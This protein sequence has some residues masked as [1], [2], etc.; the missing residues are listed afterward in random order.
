MPPETLVSR[1][2]KLYAFHEWSVYLVAI[3][4]TLVIGTLV[5]PI[6]HGQLLEILMGRGGVLS[7]L[8]I[9]EAAL[10]QSDA[11]RRV[12]LEE[13]ERAIDRESTVVSAL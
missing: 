4:V 1:R 10:A 5:P 7:L 8:G 6:M 11:A 13:A 12:S 3:G 9:D 2:V